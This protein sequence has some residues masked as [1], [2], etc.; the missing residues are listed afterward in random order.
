MLKALLVY[1]NQPA[2]FD[3]PHDP[4]EIEQ[5]TLSAGHYQP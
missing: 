5:Y 4:M 2:F 1:N 3:L